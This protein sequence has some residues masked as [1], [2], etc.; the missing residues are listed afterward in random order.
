MSNTVDGLLE[1]YEDMVEVL[2][3]LEI[4]LII[5]IINPLTGRVVGAP[6]MSLQP[7][8]CS[9]C[10]LGVP[11]SPVLHCPLGLRKLQAC[12]FHDVVFQPLPLSALSSSPFRCAL[13]DG[14]GPI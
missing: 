12:A 7:V 2:L 14:F 10:F 4:F 1:V 6:Q 13:Q 9:C 3:V 8:F 5:I 11:F